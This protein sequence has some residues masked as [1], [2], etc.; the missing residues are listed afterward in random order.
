M[1]RKKT[2]TWL[3]LLAFFVTLAPGGMFRPGALLGYDVA[4]DDGHGG[5]V[6]TVAGRGQ[7]PREVCVKRA[8]P[9]SI[10]TGDYAHSHQ[11]L[12]LSGRGLPLQV[13]RT[14]NSQDSY[15]GPFGYG[16]KFNLEIKLAVASNGI[17]EVVTIRD[18]DGVRVE[19]T[20]SPDGSYQ[21]PPGRLDQLNKN[22]DSS[23]TWSQSGCGSCGV[24]RYEFNTSGYL[25]AIE[26]PNDNK[27]AF[28]YDAAGKL[29]QVTDAS[30]RSLKITYGTNNKIAV[31][32]DPADRTY[33]YAYDSA[34]NLKSYT[35]PLGNA[36]TYNYDA[37]HN[38]VSMIDSKGNTVTTITYDD[39]DRATGYTEFGGTWTYSYD[40]ANRTTYKYLPGSWSAWQYTYNSSGQVLTE[41]DPLYN[42]NTYVYNDKIY[43]TSFTDARWFKTTYEYDERGN[44]TS[45]TDPLG[46][47][48]TYTYHGTFNKVTG[49][50]DALGGVTALQYDD[51]GN[52]KK[53]IDAMGKAARLTSNAYGQLIKVTN[54]L[55]DNETFTY[56][57]Y[58]YPAS[59][60]D[61][62]GARTLTS[63][64][65]VGNLKKFTDANGNVTTFS[66][67][68]LGN[69]TS[70]TNALGN[71]T[72]YA[73][74]SNYNLVSIT[75]GNGNTS[76]F[77][78]DAYNRLTKITDPLGNETLRAYDVRGN[79]T[80][81]TDANGNVMNFSY[82]L[83]NRMVTKTFPD[84][85][86]V[87]YGYDATGNLNRLEDGK[88]NATA[89]AYNGLNRL[90]QITYAD[91]SIETFS[92][93]KAGNLAGRI[94]QKGNSISY[95]YDPLNRLLTKGYPDASEASFSY[96][97]LS[98]LLSAKN[99]DSQVK[100]TY[101]KGNRVT[102]AVQ[103]GQT[104]AYDYD[105]TGNRAKLIYP[106]GT[107][108]TY[109][110]DALNRLSKI[111][112][113]SGVFLAGLSYDK[114]SQRSKLT[115][116]NGAEAVY[117][118]DAANR[119]TSLQNR[120]TA[121]SKTISSFAYTYD[122]GIN[123]TS[124]VTS[125]GTDWYTYD[126]KYQLT[127]VTYADNETTS[128][129]FDAAGNRLSLVDGNTTSYTTNNMNQYL[130]V[131]GISHAYDGNG[132]LISD[133]VNTYQYDF[134]NHLIQVVTPEKT[135][136]FAYDAFGRRVSKSID[137]VTTKYTYDG[138]VLITEK[139]PSQGVIRF[140]YGTGIDEPLCM[141][142]TNPAAR[143]Y[144]H[145]D[146]LGSVRTITNA[147]AGL[148]EAYA[149]DAFGR[150]TITNAS[151]KVKEKSPIGNSMAFTGRIYDQESG[152][153]NYRARYFH[154][155]LG[156]FVQ[157]DPVGQFVGGAN[158]YA[159][160]GNNPINYVD[161]LGLFDWEYWKGP[162]AVGSG[163]VAGT[164]IILSGGTATPLVI[165]GAALLGGG[166]AGAV[167]YVVAE[168][169]EPRPCART[170][171]Q[172]GWS[173]VKGF[174][175]GL[176][177]ASL[178]TTIY[179]GGEIL[180]AQAAKEAA[181]KAAQSQISAAVAN[182]DAVL[183]RQLLTR[184]GNV[185]PKQ[186]VKN[187]ISNMNRIG[188]GHRGTIFPTGL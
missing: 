67:D 1:I 90:T 11:D 139:S 100:Y 5:S 149:Y 74:D 156:R 79:V 24:P 130:G 16:W 45:V 36:T 158:L 66:Y 68:T 109:T 49:I 99:P 121:S 94:D 111:K 8:S 15:D 119:L 52:L 185:L 61:A 97:A 72:T 82:D 129:Q 157:M 84:G 123:R 31:I 58:G 180:A 92:Y 86:T 48:T 112:N 85:T 175:Y 9:V 38:L 21:A 164:I 167:T 118:Y 29:K 47:K 93:D 65:V 25:V 177:G 166:T 77:T 136:S 78:Y 96:D 150:P 89:Y 133:G 87:K 161:P 10:R 26:D 71:V 106:D 62:L 108:L 56:D 116:E 134:D 114:A 91:A 168:G 53:T 128:Y 143:Y 141:M 80:S 54:A 170:W 70:T 20:R 28:S 127:G 155:S 188:F 33:A 153:Y 146:G 59:R 88:G 101:D 27:L 131:A 34:G 162:L 107:Y 35:D 152:L 140:V 23:Y 22:A 39:Q 102:K 147:T 178:P 169:Q 81:E 165:G 187:V 13:T 98:R 132:N 154:P 113:S 105:K 2:I 63:Y 51:H 151:G 18:G 125:A 184:F 124:M 83:D 171:G 138:D 73:Y 181:I 75:D 145:L 182:G 142:K 32:T 7:S 17:Q 60:T 76:S 159:Y 14:Y 40:S 3:V 183:V 122:K 174:G 163:L 104:I 173:T 46:N 160:V 50:T 69:L 120:K 135:I 179:A 55:G 137:G 30:G 19:F 176:F 4:N 12:F 144:Y 115:L 37:K 57:T 103:D 41:R 186:W 43:L 117:Q 64:D 172:L 42:T 6:M 95:T 126:K 148:V 44:R 110:Y